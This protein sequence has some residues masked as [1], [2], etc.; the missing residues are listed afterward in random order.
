MPWNK[1][2]GGGNKGPWGEG[3]W[4][5]GPRKP[6]G[7]G[8]RGP[9]QPPDLDELLRRGQDKLKDIMPGGGGRMTWIAPI[10]LIAAFVLFNS[11]YQV[12]T[13]ER[14]VVLRLGKHV[15][16]AVPGLHFALWPIETM[17]KPKVEADSVDDSPAPDVAKK[18][19]PV[20]VSTRRKSTL[21]NAT[22]FLLDETKPD[23][24]TVFRPNSVNE[25]II[26][27]STP[28]RFMGVQNARQ[29]SRARGAR[30]KHETPPFRAGFHHASEACVLQRTD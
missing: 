26:K 8:P 12:Q 19:W 1:D 23:S 24:P 9:G 3:P 14:G 15:R 10:V 20:D 25:P 30:R 21:A 7:G 18:T 5:Q 13:D 17:E 29:P 11:I 16:T 2:G 22:C 6:G 28:T 4:G 27:A